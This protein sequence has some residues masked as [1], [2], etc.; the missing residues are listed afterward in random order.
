MEGYGTALAQ[1]NVKFM[2]EPKTITDPNTKYRNG[3]EG[4]IR[5]VEDKVMLR[6]PIRGK[7]V[8]E[9]RRVKNF[10]SYW[11][12][13]WNEQKRVLRRALAMKDGEFQY[14]L[15]IFMWPRGEGKSVLTKLILLWRF[16]CFP[17]MTIMLGANS[18]S[19]V[20]FH[21]FDLM[22]D[23]ILHSPK[24][25]DDLGTRNN[26]LQTQIQLKDDDGRITSFIR[27]VSSESGI[28]SGCSGYCFNEF[29]QAKKFKF[30][31]EID[32]SMRG[33][34]N[35]LGVIDTTV[36]SKTHILFKLYEAAKSRK[37]EY[38]FFSYRVTK[39]LHTQFWNPIINQSQKYLNS[40]KV[41]LPF[42]EYERFFLNTWSAGS[43]RVFTDELIEAVN[44]F[45][46]DKQL[47]THKGLIKLLESKN[48]LISQEKKLIDKGDDEEILAEKIKT[49]AI[50]PQ[51]F[52][53]HR[54]R[55]KEIDE[56]LWPVEDV[57]HLRSS[58]G[59]TPIM[60][61]V[62]SLDRL[63]D[64]YDTNW[65]IMAGID[66]ADPMKSRTGARTIVT[67]IAKGLAGS[68]SN[69]Y[70]VDGSGAP[71]YLYFLLHLV[72]IE[73][74]SIERIKDTLIDIDGMYDGIDTMGS[75]R[76]GVVDLEGW[77]K[78]KEIK[79]VIY[80][81]SYSRQRT[82]FAEMYLA[83]KNGRF[84][85]PPL[86][87]PGS[88]GDDVLKEEAAVFDHNP[89]ATRGKF[90][91]PEKYERYG[92]QDDAMFSIGSAIYGGLTLGVDSFRQRTGRADFGQFF[93]TG[94]HEGRY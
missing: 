2:T 69:P 77:C 3:G 6:I 67:A 65:A 14:R 38:L 48:K 26:L 73:D 94:S 12:T 60:A 16:F 40:Q 22:K 44:F 18:V 86:C 1:V 56:R 84:K 83:Y 42:G 66:R 81:P 88:K 52:E 17:N 47:G 21:H 90:G 49:A 9:W 8:E 59:G 70:P 50:V 19:Q 92:I 29:H 75:E 54:G 78:D 37:D 15:I 24:L 31:T 87:V 55:F 80:Y 93:E 11:K 61:T 25:L 30:F 79:P 76:W 74:N 35:G 53:Q 23:T 13:M 27:P 45:G 62:D 32:S 72:N 82:M 91:S 68:R 36:S 57:Y 46:I 71:R 39:G 10:P 58:D 28:W 34:R 7:D 41:R 20:K 4:F 85:A 63:S 64:M 43:E 51:L 89:D 5:W 33:I